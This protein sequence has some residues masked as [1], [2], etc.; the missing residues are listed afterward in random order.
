VFDFTSADSQKKKKKGFLF[1]G[2]GVLTKSLLGERFNPA[3]M[4]SLN[5]L[6]SFLQAVRPFI[7]AS[8]AALKRT[9]P[10]FVLFELGRK[11]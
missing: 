7:C 3:S 10:L 2:G 1:N 8:S 4:L 9:L 6:F 5:V 11:D